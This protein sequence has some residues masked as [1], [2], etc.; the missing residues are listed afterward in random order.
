MHVR[1]GDKG[2]EMELIPF[3]AYVK[4]AEEYA[5]MNMIMARKECFISTEDVKVIEEAKE[6]ANAWIS[7]NTTSNQNWT[8]IWSDI[9]RINGGPKEQLNKFGN[10]TDMTISK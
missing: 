6:T 2:I 9:P 1:H 7:P 4:K 10:R 3:S 5:A 8:W